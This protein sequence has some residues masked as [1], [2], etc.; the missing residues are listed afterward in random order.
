M[1][2][3]KK[4]AL[5][6]QFCGL[7]RNIQKEVKSRDATVI[8]VVWTQ[9]VERE[10]AKLAESLRDCWPR[11]FSTTFLV[12]QI[13]PLLIE[14]AGGPVDEETSARFVS[15]ID[16][17]ESF[18][19]RKLCFAPIDGVSLGNA[20]PVGLGPFQLRKGTALELSRL[21]EFEVQALTWTKHTPE[22]QRVFAEHFRV[23]LEKQLAGS[24]ILELEVTAD[25]EQG[26]TVFYEK[27]TSLIDLLQSSTVLTDFSDSAQIGLRGHSHAGHYSAWVLPLNCGGFFQPNE[28]T[29][30]MGELC[31]NDGSLYRMKD[32]GIMRLAEALGREATPLESTLLRAVHWFAHS[33]LQLNAAQRT[34]SLVVCLETILQ[35]S[36][37]HQV[38]EAVAL[39]AGATT[40]ERRQ[41]Y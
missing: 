32:A 37:R 19:E 30:S 21:H 5:I 36:S 11:K 14:L 6:S 23:H 38:A 2:A 24:V 22:E 15:L 41:M 8:E 18:N 33:T 1:D 7:I 17:L 35:R 13:K 29:G 26:H 9:A 4:S 28:R 40:A 3:K 39:L 16:T 31:L 20:A 10:C 25:A 27:A 12:R 34:L